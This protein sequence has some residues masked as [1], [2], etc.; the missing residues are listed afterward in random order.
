MA[1]GDIHNIEERLNQID[2]RIIRID[3]DYHKERYKIIAWDEKEHCEYIAF[4]V[5][6]G[7]LDARVEREVYRIRPRPGYNPFDE[8]RRMEEQKERDDERKIED[9]ARDMAETIYKP[10]LYDA[11][12]A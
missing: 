6:W 1:V 8:L 2:P 12:G 5:P 9:M 10:L 11:F 4:T 7:E 3:F